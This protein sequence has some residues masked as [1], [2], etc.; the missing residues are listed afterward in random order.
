VAEFVGGR[1]DAIALVEG[2][3]DE[4]LERSAVHIEVGR[5]TISNL[6]GEWVFHDRNHVRQLLADTQSRAWVGMGNARRFSHPDR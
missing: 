5:V 4:D 3:R 1:D 6:L 2:L